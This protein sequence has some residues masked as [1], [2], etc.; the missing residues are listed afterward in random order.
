MYLSRDILYKYIYINPFKI[1][2]WQHPKYIVLSFAFFPT[3]YI[4]SVVS[5]QHIEV[6][7][8]LKNGGAVHFVWDVV[9]FMGLIKLLSVSDETS[10]S[11]QALRIGSHKSVTTPGKRR[12]MIFFEP[13]F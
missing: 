3:Q 5:Y 1:H 4:L 7:L 6:F 10:F 12:Q 13:Y 2:K 11:P 8:T 9:Y